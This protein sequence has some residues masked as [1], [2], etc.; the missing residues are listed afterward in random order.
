MLSSVSNPA[1]NY[2]ANVTYARGLENANHRYHI[3]S[4]YKKI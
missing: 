4:H 1:E 2:S 3:F